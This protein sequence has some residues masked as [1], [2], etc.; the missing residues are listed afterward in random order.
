MAAVAA[1]FARRM[2]AAGAGEGGGAEQ[3]GRDQLGESTASVGGGAETGSAGTETK[4]GGWYSGGTSALSNMPGRRWGCALSAASA[5]KPPRRQRCSANSAN[6]AH[7]LSE[8]KRIS[9]FAAPTS[10]T[11]HQH[12]ARRALHH[13]PQEVRG[14]PPRVV[15]LLTPQACCPA[16]RQGQ[17]VN[18]T[19]FA[20]GSHRS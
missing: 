9:Q 11:P 4:R 20:R 3:R 10:T 8:R 12:T 16:P 1:V 17:E 6:S 2:R 19:A 7:T 18:C 13:V 15:G 14:S 5:A